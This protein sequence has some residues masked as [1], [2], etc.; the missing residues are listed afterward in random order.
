MTVPA[1]ILGV[2]HRAIRPREQ[3]VGIGAVVG[4]DRDTDADAEL[5][6]LHRERRGYRLHD[7]RGD[8]PRLVPP[9]AATQQHDK[10]VASEPRNRIDCAS[11]GLQP[12]GGLAQHKVAGCMAVD[13]VDWLESI[14]IDEQERES[15]GLR[16]RPAMACSM[17]IAAAATDWEG[18]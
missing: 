16:R 10:L 17:S 9:V 14:E 11:G 15:A 3:L 7:P 2:V 8:E 13:I 5:Q 12:A 18:R 1:A 6:S 4:K